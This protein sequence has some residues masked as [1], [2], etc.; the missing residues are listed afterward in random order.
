[1][2]QGL[3]ARGLGSLSSTEDAL[4]AIG[5]KGTEGVPDRRR[6]EMGVARKGS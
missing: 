5:D 2:K 3:S 6:Q 4:A 1:M